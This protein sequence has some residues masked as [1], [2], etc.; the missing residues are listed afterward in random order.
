M[1]GDDLG[2]QARE[3]RRSSRCRPRRLRRCGDR[4]SAGARPA[5]R[6]AGRAGSPCRWRRWRRAFRVRAS[7]GSLSQAGPSGR[8]DAGKLSHTLAKT[9][10]QAGEPEAAAP[11]AVGWTDS[12]TARARARHAARRRRTERGS[13]AARPLQQPAD[14]APGRLA[15]AALRRRRARV[16][17]H[18]ARPVRLPRRFRPLARGDCG[19]PCLGEVP[20]RRRGPLRSR[21]RA[22]PAA[23]PR[24]LRPRALA[25]QPAPAA[26]SGRLLRASRRRRCVPAAGSIL[27]EYVGPKYFQFSDAPAPHHRRAARGAAAAAAAALALAAV[28]RRSTFRRRSPTSWRTRRTR[29]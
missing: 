22:R 6:R 13:L 1:G 28:R 19:G 7:A 18:A 9:P 16:P 15:V 29:R 25:V 26:R 5:S 12:Q 14:L 3:S 11:A 8:S 27:N 23:R 10:P 4:R 2:E 20:R 17:R 21:R 24:R